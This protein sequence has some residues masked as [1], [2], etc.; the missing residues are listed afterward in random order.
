MSDRVNGARLRVV[1]FGGSGFLGRGLRSRLVA[2]GHSVVVVGRERSA[3]HAGWEHVAWDART[4]DGWESV[5]DGA[6]VI[7]HLAGK[8]V[9]CRPTHANVDELISSRVDTVRL[10]GEA[11]RLADS[12]PSVWVQL[13]SLAIFGDAGDAVI[14]EATSVP[15]D[16]PRQQVEV[17]RQ[18]EAAF[19]ES[20]LGVDRRV[21][22]R[23]GITI[24]GDGD[25]VTAQLARLARLGLGGHVGSG[26]Q[27]VSWIAADDVF[28]VLARAVTDSSMSGVYHVASP[29]PVRNRELMAA[30]RSAVGRRFGLPS[31]SMVTRV[32]AWLLGSDPALALTGRRCVPTRLLS[33]GYRF[34]VTKI[35]EAVARAVGR[36]VDVQ[37]GR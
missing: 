20:S 18:W 24:G 5:V 37:P 2:A 12:P 7:V 31:P 11:V 23:P 15:A 3:A 34:E 14:D 30:Y 4:L 6:D 8:R 13:S 35:D 1:L 29:T 26:D 17:C 21:L 33:D 28:A 19:D 27:W 36:I 32:G 9:D 10:V 25:P 22:L 16:G